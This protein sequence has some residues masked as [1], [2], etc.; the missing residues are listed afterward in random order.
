MSEIFP[1]FRFFTICLEKVEIECRKPD[2]VQLHQSIQTVTGW[3]GGCQA[4]HNLC[5]SHYSF[6]QWIFYYC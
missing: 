2:R 6:I 3:I 5:A 4:F 1:V